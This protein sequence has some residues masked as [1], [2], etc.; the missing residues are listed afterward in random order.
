MLGRETV[1]YGKQQR[2]EQH[3]VF[4]IAARNQVGITHALHVAVA[5]GNGY[6]ADARAGLERPAG[7]R[8]V[9]EN[10][11][12][13]FV[14]HDDIASHVH[15][16]IGAVRFLRGFREFGRMLQGMKIGPAY[17]AGQRL[18]QHLT[19]AGLRL[20]DFID[21]ESRISH[22]GRAHLVTSRP[23]CESSV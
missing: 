9:I 2:L 15:A 19:R 20:C 1:R 7:V 4:G 10:F 18:D 3:H 14:T 11:R 21:D 8:A 17:T 23:N 5:Q 6:R 12:A 13:E 22:Y 16:E